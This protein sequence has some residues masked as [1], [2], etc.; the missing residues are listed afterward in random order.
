MPIRSLFLNA[1]QL[2]W[3]CNA[4]IMV[5]QAQGVIWACTGRLQV[6]A[7]PSR[8]VAAHLCPPLPRPCP[9]APSLLPDLHW[10]PPQSRKDV[11]GSLF[12][13]KRR[14]QPRFQF[15][16]LNKKSAGGRCSC[17]AYIL[18]VMPPG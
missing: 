15:I 6:Y 17:P 13:V 16:I 7:C 12:L 18:L 8:A 9:A 11:E 5:S 4:L 1:T 14:S 3:S 10:L 2:T